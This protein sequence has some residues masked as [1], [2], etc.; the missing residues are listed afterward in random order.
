MPILV[1]K[2]GQCNHEFETLVITSQ[3]RE[4]LKTARCPSCGSSDKEAVLTAPGGIQVNS[5][6]TTGRLTRT[7][8]GVLR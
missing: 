6:N 3:D 7:R 4:E 5:T 8:R 2:C 1:F